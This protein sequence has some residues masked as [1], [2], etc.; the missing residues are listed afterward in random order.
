MGNILEVV[1]YTLVAAVLYL[2]SDWLLDRIEIVRGERFKH[3]SIVF[4]F[5]ILVLAFISFS[6]I[7]AMMLSSE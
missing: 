2:A 7:K 5:I 4:F 1:Y 6:L 3:R